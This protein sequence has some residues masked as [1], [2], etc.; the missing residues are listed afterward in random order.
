VPGALAGWS[1]PVQAQG[2]QGTQEAGTPTEPHTLLFSTESPGE[3]K[4]ITHWGL[5]T[6]W[7]VP[8]H[9]RRGMLYMGKDNVDIIRVSFPIN[10]PLVNGDLPASKD[11]HFTTRLEIARMAGD[12]PFTMLPDTEAGVHPWF[13]N[14]REVIPE[15]WVQLMAAAQRRYGKKMESVEAFNEA[16]YGWGQGTAANLYNILGALR[17][18]PDFAGVQMGGPSTLSAG[19][20]LPWYQIIKGRLDRATT[21]SLGGNMEFYINF[22]RTVAADG[23]VADNPE[24]HNLV[25][26][27]AGAQYGLQSAI[28]WG[29]AELARGEFV[30]AVQGER[31]AYAEDRPRWSAAAVYRAPEGKV[32]A[33]LGNSERMGQPTSYRFIS[34]DRDVFFNGDGPR[35]EYNATI[36]KD[37]ELMVNITWGEDVQPKIGGRYV[38]VNRHSG[39]VLGVVGASQEN[40]AAI[41][42]M[43]YSRTTNQQ[44]EIMP[45]STRHGDQSYY[46]IR[47]IHSGKTMDLADWSHEEG[48]QVQQWGEGEAG[49]QNWFFDYAGDNYFTI[50]SRWSTKYLGVAGESKSAGA[51]IQQFSRTGAP[52][53]Q[54]RLI[55]VSAGEIELDAPE[56]PT[57]LTATAKPLAVELQWK[58]NPE[59]DVAGYAV[60]RST[61]DNGPYDT[62]ARGV[63]GNTFM[64]NKANDG[65]KYFYKVKAV[66]RCFNQSAFST[67]VSATPGGSAALAASYLFEGNADDDSGNANES[68]LFGSPAYGLGR[69]GSQAII[70]DGADD[71]VKLPDH[72]VNS[73]DITLSAWVYSTASEPWQ[74]VFDLGNDESHYL[75][76]TPNDNDGTLRLEVK[77]GAAEQR[78]E[79]PGLPGN[80][81]VHVAF[82]LG[83]KTARLYVNGAVVASSD[84]W[85]IRPADF[86]PIFNTIG[87]SQFAADPLFKGRIDNFQIYNYALTPDQVA[88]LAMKSP[89]NQPNQ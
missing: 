3:K 52:G 1:A 32:Q 59:T 6:A 44:W 27:I 36:R 40:G 53:Q 86:K 63:I 42:Q 9:L 17:N 47:A 12:K 45:L 62:I 4:A 46:A 66:D 49:A 29:T 33:F 51:G 69:D 19:A 8:D 24:V 20:A 21:H 13:K 67:P 76:F 35:R 81:W 70:L 38:L 28:W 75:F 56:Q 25:E 26:V 39:K 68:T 85:T 18:S 89:A 11:K 5:D 55:P 83:G 82:T 80:Q 74:R 87:K 10:E 48:G 41:Q 65:R 64:D 14:G 88:K 16:D 7:A 50:R 57:G 77:N 73:S 60:F 72:V 58:A 2:A 61:T 43:D 37:N 30:K 22:F 23:K 34:R 84:S 15:R 71:Y 31:L 79:A 54:W 78:L